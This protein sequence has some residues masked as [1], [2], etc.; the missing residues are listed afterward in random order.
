[1]P[2]IRPQYKRRRFQLE[3]RAKPR[4]RC[5]GYRCQSGGRAPRAAG[6]PIRQTGAEVPLDLRQAGTVRQVSRRTAAAHRLVR[7][8]GNA[9]CRRLGQV[10]R[11]P[12]R[13]GAS[14]PAAG[15]RARSLSALPALYPRP[16][17]GAS[18]FADFGPVRCWALSPR[19]CEPSVARNSRPQAAFSS[20]GKAGAVLRRGLQVS[21]ASCRFLRRKRAP[22]RIEC[23]IRPSRICARLTPRRTASTQQSI[24]RDHPAA[25]DVLAPAA[26]APRSHSRRKSACSR[27]PL[28]RSKPRTSVRGSASPLRAQPQAAP[29]RYPR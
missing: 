8:R 11:K 23:G 18:A 26:P 3:A 17:P 14:A 5:D 28:S 13:R 25:N 19:S 12:A 21:R 22:I 2:L 15:S 1:M 6:P 16:S 20:A 24:F 29:P 4:R 7:S 27:R 10:K 9:L